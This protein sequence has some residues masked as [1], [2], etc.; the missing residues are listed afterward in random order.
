M[1]LL[2]GLNASLWFQGNTPT[3]TFIEGV[4]IYQTVLTIFLL[5]S[6]YHSL[7][8]AISIRKLRK[9]LIEGKPID[10]HAPWKKLFGVQN[11]I[12]FLLTIILL[13]FAVIPFLQLGKMETK[14]LPADTPDLPIVRL[15]D[16]EKN[17]DLIRDDSTYVSDDVDWGNHYSFNWSPIAPVQYDTL[18]SGI[19]PEEVYSPYIDTEVY[20]LS[21]RSLADNLISDLIERNIY[22]IYE[23]DNFI[24]THHSNL[25]FLV[26][27]E[28]DGMKKVIAHKGKGVMLV[29][30]HGDAD[31]DAVIASI[32]E[33]IQLISE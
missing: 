13:L 2:V 31:M 24:E 9:N 18:E 30:Y 29:S 8:A 25:D 4:A 15:A 17:P 26:V 12:G 22:D 1:I 6:T 10:H 27:F 21:I 11:S 32:I 23:K 3:L 20:Q 33:K 19:I 5:Y 28:D 16:I 7:Q 14:T